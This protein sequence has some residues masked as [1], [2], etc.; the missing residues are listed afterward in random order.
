MHTCCTT[1][2]P[3]FGVL[4]WISLHHRQ[5]ERS[6]L[7]LLYHG[8]VDWLESTGLPGGEGD[9]VPHRRGLSMCVR[10]SCAERQ[11]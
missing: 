2:T 4:E 10:N 11:S 7:P 5:S 8:R 1:N 3:L 6:D 9:R